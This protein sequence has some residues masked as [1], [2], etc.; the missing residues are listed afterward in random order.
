MTPQGRESLPQ[1]YILSG[2]DATN[3]KNGYAGQKICSLP[4]PAIVSPVS[5]Q[6]TCILQLNIT[7]SDDVD[8]FD[9][10]DW[11]RVLNGALE[12]GDVIDEQY[13]LIQQGLNAFPESEVPYF[14]N[15]TP[16]CDLY[17]AN[18][19]TGIK[20]PL[21]P[22]LP[23]W[24]QCSMRDGADQRTDTGYLPSES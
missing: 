14:P 8:R 24:Q 11:Y 3:P 13:T 10:K 5:A 16:K 21:L 19:A 22:V 20:A 17:I 6:L 2:P 9:E 4:S 7:G 1:T 18:G 15:P 12:I 23:L